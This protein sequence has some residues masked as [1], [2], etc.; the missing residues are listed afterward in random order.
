MTLIEIGIFLGLIL[1]GVIIGWPIGFAQGQRHE[2]R[3]RRP[4]GERTVNV[5]V[6]SGGI[7]RGGD[8]ILN[9]EVIE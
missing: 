1:A 3:A 7:R 4:V 5:R 8:R 2:R 9:A 6:A